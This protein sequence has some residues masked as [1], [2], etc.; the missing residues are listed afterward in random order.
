MHWCMLAYSYCRR[1]VVESTETSSKQAPACA[2]Y[3]HARGQVVNL[4]RAAVEP[5]LDLAIRQQAAIIFKQLCRSE[6][7]PAGASW[8]LLAA[9]V[10]LHGLHDMLARARG[11]VC[12]RAVRSPASLVVRLQKASASWLPRT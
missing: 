6:W 4:L 9:C 3:K 8:Q 11:Q 2:Q 10:R 5:S 7:D 12:R 1:F